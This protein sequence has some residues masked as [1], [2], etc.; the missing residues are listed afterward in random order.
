[1]KITDQKVQDAIDSCPLEYMPYREAKEL[2]ESFIDDMVDKEED[3]REYDLDDVIREYADSYTDVYTS[4]LIGKF[5]VYYRA[6]RDA[7]EEF[8]TNVDLGQILT[9]GQSYAHERTLTDFVRE[10]F[11]L[12]D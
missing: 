11:E 1:M 2:I 5:R 8:G 12:E 3:H 10:L 9:Q 6:T 7:L 4:D